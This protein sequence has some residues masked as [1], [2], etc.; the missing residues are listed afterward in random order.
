MKNTQSNKVLN[1][2]RAAQCVTLPAQCMECEDM[3]ITDIFPTYDCKHILIVL[4][5]SKSIRSFL[6]LYKLDFSGKMCKIVDEPFLLKELEENEVPM[7]INLLPFIDKLPSTDPLVKTIGNAVMVCTDGAVRIVNLDT[8]KRV[9]Y[10]RIS[11]EN[12]VSA[13]YCNSK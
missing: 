4:K 8:L 6:I 10:G 12:F 3:Q 2:P 5:C 1:Y 11:D 9:C 13:V 7:E